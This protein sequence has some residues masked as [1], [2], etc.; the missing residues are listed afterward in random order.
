VRGQELVEQG[1]GAVRVPEEVRGMAEIDLS[2]R[3][4]AQEQL[5]PPRRQPCAGATNLRAAVGRMGLQEPDG[6][7]L[8]ISA[9]QWRAFIRCLKAG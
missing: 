9:V 2:P 7:G 3:R 4:V 8:L 5:Q 6:P 1:D